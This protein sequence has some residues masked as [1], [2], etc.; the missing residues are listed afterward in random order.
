MSIEVGQEAWILLP[1]ADVRPKKGHYDVALGHCCGNG[2][3][4]IELSLDYLGLGLAWE[5]T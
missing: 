5:Y 2:F 1:L 4:V 3:G